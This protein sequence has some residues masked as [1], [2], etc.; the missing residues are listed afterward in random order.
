M[1]HK[2]WKL[3]GYCLDTVQALAMAAI[4]MLLLAGG[5]ALE[6]KLLGTM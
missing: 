4:L 3:W 6:V 5:H 2:A 1:S